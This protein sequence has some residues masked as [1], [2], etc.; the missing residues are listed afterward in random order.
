MRSRFAPGAARAGLLPFCLVLLAAAP[1]AP[2]SVPISA[3]GW[4]LL[5]ITR[6]RAL[7]GDAHA[8]WVSYWAALTFEFP[9]SGRSSR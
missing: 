7:A 4:Q 3:P 6:M 2:V 1:A 8:D 9:K 5:G